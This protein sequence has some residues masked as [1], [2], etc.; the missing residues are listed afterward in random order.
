ML[1]GCWPL[2]LPIRLLR[3]PKDDTD[4]GAVLGNGHKACMHQSCGLFY[5]CSQAYSAHAVKLLAAPASHQ[6][7]ASPKTHMS[8][9]S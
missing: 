5:A 2:L 4:V 6:A 1:S 7:L 8:Y 9:L 3:A